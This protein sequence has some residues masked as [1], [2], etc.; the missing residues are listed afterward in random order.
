MTDGLDKAIGLMTANKEDIDALKDGCSLAGVF[1][2]GVIVISLENG[3]L[4]FNVVAGKPMFYD[5]ELG[6]LEQEVQHD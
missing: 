2:D 4:K 5:I 6:L 3:T 1:P